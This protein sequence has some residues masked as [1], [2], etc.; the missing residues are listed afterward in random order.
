MK[1]GK[2]VAIIGGGN[3]A[4][5]SA[6][7]AIRLGPEKVIILYRRTGMPCPPTRKKYRMPWTRAWN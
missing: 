6:R 7:T 3:T 2:T 5:D 1:L 4:I